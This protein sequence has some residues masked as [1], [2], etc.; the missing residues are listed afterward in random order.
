MRFL[1]KRLSNTIIIILSMI[2]FGFIGYQA[3][4][5]TDKDVYRLKMQL[6]G[7]EHLIVEICDFVEEKYDIDVIK[8][9]N[10]EIEHLLREAWEAEGMKPNEIEKNIE[11][12]KKH[13][14][15]H[16]GF[17]DKVME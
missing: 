3:G 14:E 11:V 17:I 16:F 2:I 13:W 7:Y 4:R 12:L 1:K 15:N 10:L 9:M 6:I 5:K 8:E